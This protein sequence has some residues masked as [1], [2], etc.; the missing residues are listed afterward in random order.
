[1]NEFTHKENAVQNDM[2]VNNNWKQM[3]L[4]WAYFAD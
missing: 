4:K 3:G 1:L 2:K